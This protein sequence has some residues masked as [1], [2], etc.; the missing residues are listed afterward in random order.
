MTAAD[1]AIHIAYM[2]A[3]DNAHRWLLQSNDV[4]AGLLAEI[5]ELR[6]ELQQRGLPDEATRLVKENTA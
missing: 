4:P 6:Q 2:N 1:R 5:R 3:C